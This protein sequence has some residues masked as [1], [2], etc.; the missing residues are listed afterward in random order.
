MFQLY[1]IE[2]YSEDAVRQ[3]FVG[4][5]N[6]SHEKENENGNEDIRVYHYNLGKAITCFCILNDTL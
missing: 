2:A 4:I 6:L 1:T 5:S 3:F